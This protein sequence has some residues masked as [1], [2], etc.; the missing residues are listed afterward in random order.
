MGASWCNPMANRDRRGARACQPPRVAFVREGRGAKRRR[1]RDIVHIMSTPR[2]LSRLLLVVLPL[3]AADA[4]AALTHYETFKAGGAELHVMLYESDSKQSIAMLG[5]VVGG[6][7]TAITF[8][9]D[10]LP[11][12]FDLIKRAGAAQNGDWKVIGELRESA[13]ASDP[14]HLMIH[15]GAGGIRFTVD[16]PKIAAE[17][18]TLPAADLPRLEAALAKARD[19]ASNRPAK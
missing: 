18:F 16:S 12:L 3:V 2:L 8:Y 6:K 11:P 15:A 19:A 13:D 9:K 10:E 5:L 14:S 1:R 17:S 4:R 7:K